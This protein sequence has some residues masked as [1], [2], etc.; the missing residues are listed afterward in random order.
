MIVNGQLYDAAR[1][2][3]LH[4]VLAVFRLHASVRVKSLRS[5]L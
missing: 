2:Q 1:E 4:D 5:V 3:I